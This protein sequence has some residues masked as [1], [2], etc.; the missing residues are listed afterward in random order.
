MELPQIAY[1]LHFLFSF[2]LSSL[3]PLSVLFLALLSPL[4]FQRSL[5]IAFSKAVLFSKP[6][7]RDIILVLNCVNKVCWTVLTKIGSRKCS[8]EYNKQHQNTEFSLKAFLLCGKV[9]SQVFCEICNYI[10][11]AACSQEIYK[12]SITSNVSN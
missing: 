8:T 10:F 9:K 5:I 4:S 2:S 3:C 6:Q 11:I 12:G 1:L 7:G